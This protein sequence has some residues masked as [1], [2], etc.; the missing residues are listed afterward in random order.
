MGNREAQGADDEQEGRAQR[1]QTEVR[2]VFDSPLKH[3]S[4]LE[5]LI[6]DAIQT[7]P[8]FFCCQL[9]DPKRGP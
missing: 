3:V 5:K 8:D 2:K 4:F 6:Y 9:H 7:A 1:R